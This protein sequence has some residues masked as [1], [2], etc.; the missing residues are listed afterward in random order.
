MISVVREGVAAF[1]DGACDLV[2]A[3]GGGSAIDAGKAIAAAAANSGD[4]LDYLEVIGKGQPLGSEPYPF[5]AVPTTA[6]TGSEVTRQCR[7]GLDG[8]MA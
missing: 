8:S 6:G 7:A 5:I 2:I 3:I 1:H 4:L